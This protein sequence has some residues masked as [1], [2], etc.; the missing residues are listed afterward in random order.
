VLEN[1]IFPLTGQP[2]KQYK[3]MGVTGGIIER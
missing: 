3:F 1:N 2:P